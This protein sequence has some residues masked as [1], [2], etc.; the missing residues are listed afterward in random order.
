MRKLKPSL[1]SVDD[2]NALVEQNIRLTAWAVKRFL[3][4]RPFLRHLQDDLLQEAH[5]AL[6]RSADLW[7][8]QKGEFSTFASFGLKRRLQH[9]A[10]RMQGT[11]AVPARLPPAEQ[12][13]LAN[14]LAPVELTTEVAMTLTTTDDPAEQ[15][16]TMDLIE[17]ALQRLP[18][19]LEKLTRLRLAGWSLQAV[20]HAWQV[21]PQ[22]ISQLAEKVTERLQSMAA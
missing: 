11:I 18:P 3:K 17:V 22:R 19:R 9:F 1:R 8:P 6:L 4:R 20:A 14:R 7:D 15:V 13:E 16:E 21:S 5:L 2:R 10:R 12:F